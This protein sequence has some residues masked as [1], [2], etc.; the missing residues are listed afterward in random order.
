[1]DKAWPLY[2]QP[3]DV[4]ITIFGAVSENLPAAIGDTAAWMEKWGWIP[5]KHGNVD[6]AVSPGHDT[7]P[8]RDP[9][10]P[11]NGNDARQQGLTIIYDDFLS[12]PQIAGVPIRPGADGKPLPIAPKLPVSPQ[13][14][15]F[16]EPT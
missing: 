12:N 14:L 3:L 5:P 2:G 6:L 15:Y 10:D 9:L 11:S 7:T 4:K 8:Y 16:G 13:L 1:V